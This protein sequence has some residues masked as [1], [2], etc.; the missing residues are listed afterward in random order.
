MYFPNSAI[1]QATY[2]LHIQKY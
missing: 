1:V 2:W